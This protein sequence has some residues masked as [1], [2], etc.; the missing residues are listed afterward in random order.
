[1]SELDRWIPPHTR[2]LIEQR[3]YAPVNEQ[4]RL[5]VL[6]HNPGFW[7]DLADHVGLM[8]DHGVVHMR[9]VA[10]QVLRVL[11]AVHGVLIPSR[12]AA[13]FAFMQTY[14]VLA[15]CLHDIGNFDFS[16]FGRLMHPEFASQQ[17]FAPAQDDI[18]QGIWHASGSAVV[19]RLQRLA[20]QGQL[21]QPP[22]TVLRELLAM[23]MA[24]SKSKVPI[25]VLN[26]PVRLRQ[27]LIHTISTELHELCAWQ[28]SGSLPDTPL[29]SS[30]DVLWFYGDVA[31]KAYGWLV[32][33]EPALAELVADV[34]DT[35]RVLRSADALRQRGTVL[36]TSGGYEI[37]VDQQTANAIFA[38][39]LGDDRLYLL[40]GLSPI[41]AGEAN[42]ASSELDHS[43]HLRVSFHRGAFS[44]AGAVA[45]AAACA[46]RV[47]EDIAADVITSFQRP[48]G[49]AALAHAQRAAAMQILIEET[50]DNL[51]FG[52]LVCEQV[53]KI[54]PALGPRVCIVPSL[55]QASALERERYLEGE[56]VTWE[57]AARMQLLARVGQSGHAIQAIDPDQAF[58]HVKLVELEPGEVLIEAG[59]PS[60]FVYIPLEAGLQIIPLGGYESFSVQAWMPLGVTGVIRGAVRNATVIARQPVQL[61]AIPRTVFLKQWHATHHPEAFRALHNI[62]LTPGHPT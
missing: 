27:V 41:S 5:E 48:T 7:D 2:A 37:F 61:L 17:M 22:Q 50:D 34:I 13:R 49:E 36:K 59:A 44:G 42:L 52:N 14:G 28:R 25:D 21:T 43:G 20:D 9:D 46:A 33:D 11:D 35:L 39:R 3:F 45:Y 51:D 23:P 53:A 15:A 12:G 31:S 58:E 56:T 30:P 4:A 24:H 1:M 6:L 54:N 62:R 60:A 38:L 10:Q 16:P 29:C 40:L 8:A 26:D 18:V 19:T 32:A 57:R 47:I 55:E